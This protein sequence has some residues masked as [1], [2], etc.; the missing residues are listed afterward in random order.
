[1]SRETTFGTDLHPKGDREKLGEIFTELCVRVS[2]DLKRK[3]YV[4]RTVGIKLRFQDFQTV[5]RDYTVPDVTDD[6]VAIRRA[7]TECLKRIKLAQRIR[8][9]GVRVSGLERN[10]ATRTGMPRQGD[11]F[12]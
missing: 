7:A 4:G 3:G 8:L 12:E 5:T 1:M 11:L 9:L 2:E 10:D 6:A